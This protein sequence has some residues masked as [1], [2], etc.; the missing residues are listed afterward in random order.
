MGYIFCLV[1][2]SIM[3]NLIES[4]NKRG[5]G[6]RVYKKKEQTLLP[7]KIKYNNSVV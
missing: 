4:S 5:P 3:N 6:I 2:I 1:M 7:S